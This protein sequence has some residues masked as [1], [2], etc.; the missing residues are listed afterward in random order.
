MAHMAATARLNRDYAIRMLGVGAM[1]AGMTGWAL[2]DGAAGY[3]RMNA[4]YEAVRPELVGRAMTAGEWIKPGGGDGIS[5]V[6]RVFRDH[7]MR[8][9]AS[10]LAKLKALNEQARGQTVPPEQA[11]SFRAR[12]VEA[13]RELLDRPPRSPHEIR[14]QFV[15]A[16]LAALA[17][18][19]AF[20][21][22]GR[23]AGR[24]LTADETGLRGFAAQPVPYE[25]IRAADWSQWEAKRI[26]RLALR[27]GRRL[28]LDGWHFAG[29]E[30][31]VAEL[32][33]HRP[34]LKPEDGDAP[35]ETGDAPPGAKE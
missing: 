25:A 6:E 15:M 28:K 20:A 3:P 26:V 16:A 27:D 22:V 23:K 10:M 14:S 24:R 2:Y 19:A 5:E 11:E 29:A 7:G 17:A 30:E 32:L 31:V 21:A 33:R 8:A 35:R 34:D 9:P 13:A 12:Q 4:R 18:L 1:L